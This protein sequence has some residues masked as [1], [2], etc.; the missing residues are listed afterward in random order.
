[1][2]LRQYGVALVH[3]VHNHP[4]GTQVKH[5]FQGKA[6]ALHLFPDAV[7]VL[8]AALHLAIHPQ[9]LQLGHQLRASLVHA[10]FALQ[11]LLVQRSGQ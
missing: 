2:Q 9:A 1:V 4:Q 6:F 5:P 8:G 3:A 10:Q 11:A 7:E